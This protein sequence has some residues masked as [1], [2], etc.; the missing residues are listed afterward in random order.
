VCDPCV[1]RKSEIKKE[2]ERNAK[3]GKETEGERNIRK[4]RKREK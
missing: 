2:I 1:N 3:R 4:N